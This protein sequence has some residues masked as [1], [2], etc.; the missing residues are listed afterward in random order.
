MGKP[1]VAGSFQVRSKE[2]QSDAI[3]NRKRALVLKTGMESAQVV[4]IL[5]S[6]KAQATAR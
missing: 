2:Q 1:A 5:S 3:R 6:S 4:I